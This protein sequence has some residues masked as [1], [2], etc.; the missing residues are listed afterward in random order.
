MT[1]TQS[2]SD[3]EQTTNI[4]VNIR[5]EPDKDALRDAITTLVQTDGVTVSDEYVQT[6][7]DVL[8]NWD[9]FVDEYETTMEHVITD[10][11]YEFYADNPHKTPTDGER[12]TY[13]LQAWDYGWMVSEV[14]DVDNDVAT[15]VESDLHADGVWRL[16]PEIV[17][18]TENDD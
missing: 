15:E 12:T 9:A 2:H 14:S 4:T 17:I 7:L 10:A 11:L 8:D 13:D 18:R 6:L 16:E 1:Q 3:D 5:T